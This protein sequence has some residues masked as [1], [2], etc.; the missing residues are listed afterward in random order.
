MHSVCQLD[1]FGVL[2]ASAMD[3]G[4]EHASLLWA[5][6]RD[7][8]HSADGKMLVTKLLPGTVSGCVWSAL[9]NGDKG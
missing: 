6:F 4:S 7:L 1:S 3:F 9:S 8:V 2:M 5:V